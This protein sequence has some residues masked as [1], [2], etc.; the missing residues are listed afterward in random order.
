MH[1]G[2]VFHQCSIQIENMF[3]HKCFVY[4]RIQND[5]YI[6]FGQWEAIFR[7][8]TELSLFTNESP[9]SIQAVHPH[10]FNLY[11]KK[12]VSQMYA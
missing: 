1:F 6:E 12:N 11:H 5:F 4:R 9:L 2:I 8:F 3:K 7:V 10:Y